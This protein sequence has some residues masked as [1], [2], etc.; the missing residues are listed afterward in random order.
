MTAAA[1]QT[2]SPHAANQPY[3]PEAAQLDST[4]L[5]YN[6]AT[7]RLLATNV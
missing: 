1:L 4:Q 3:C 6:Y 7:G 5:N 2:K